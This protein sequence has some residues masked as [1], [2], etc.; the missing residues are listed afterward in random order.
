MN[1]VKDDL[2]ITLIALIVTII[3]LLILAGITITMVMGDNGIL[4]HARDSKI[5]TEIAQETEEIRLAMLS[6]KTEKEDTN[7]SVS[8]KEVEDE[9]NRSQANKVISHGAYVK[10]NQSGREYLI[11]ENGVSEEPIEVKDVTD[12]NPGEFA[13][14]GNERDPYR[15]ESIEDLVALSNN[16]NSGEDY[17]GKYF[18]L[19]VSLDFYSENSYALASS[20]EEG[21]LMDQLTSGEGFRHIGGDWWYT[22]DTSTRTKIE[23]DTY[24]FSATFDG[25]GN[26]IS[27]LYTN[28]QRTIVT[29]NISDNLKKYSIF[30]DSGSLF[31]K[32][33]GNIINLTVSRANITSSYSA[34][35]IAE[36]NFGIMDNCTFN[37][38]VNVST[39]GSGITI[40]N[41]GTLSNC[42]SSGSMEGK[43]SMGGICAYMSENGIIR[44]SVNSMT[45]TNIEGFG[46]GG[47]CYSCDNTSS[48]INC[49]N[50]ADIYAEIA[51]SNTSYLPKVGGVCAATDGDITYCYNTGNITQYGYRTYP[52]GIAGYTEGNIRNC[53][54]TGNI[55]TNGGYSTRAG[56][57]AG[58]VRASLFIEDCYNIGNLTVE[59]PAVYT[60]AGGIAGEINTSGAVNIKN[61]YNI[62]NIGGVGTGYLKIGGLIGE[63]KNVVTLTNSYYLDT[64]CSKMYSNA[65]PTIVNSSSKTEL[66]MKTS[67]FLE[68][69]NSNNSWQ[70]DTNINNGYPSLILL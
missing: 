69:I 61:C 49:S 42:S 8:A 40:F 41:Y 65:E 64:A 13:G 20:L 6:I 50:T 31:G 63:C 2:G 59:S 70:I 16:V 34:S 33:Y 52:G 48:I 18:I 12:T 54:N 43:G 21:G 17:E 46:V 15:I 11:D 44:D 28:R 27:N 67:E 23:E 38:K 37:G 10:Y 26:S 14:S 58:T 57:I 19:T 24:R 5:A 4:N 22:Y 1:K 51:Q 47:V 60:K 56:G 9:I 62:G 25:N 30:D 39:Y 35:G 32:L 45:I 66:E 36:Y 55:K 29:E 7:A 53:Y 68:L 3:I